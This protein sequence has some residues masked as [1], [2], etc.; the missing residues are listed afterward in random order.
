MCGRICVYVGV[1]ECSMRCFFIFFIFIFYKCAWAKPR[2]G[3]CVCVYMI[4]AMIYM[5]IEVYAS[6]KGLSLLFVH[7]NC[8]LGGM[9][10]E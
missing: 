1:S 3:E 10:C 6:E 8:V 7:R 2:R 9:V 4:Y 5:H